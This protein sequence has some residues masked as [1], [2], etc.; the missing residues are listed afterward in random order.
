[1]KVKNLSIP[2]YCDGFYLVSLK[3]TI[4]NASSHRN[5]SLI[6]KVYQR[7]ETP[8]LR[9][10]VAEDEV[11]D[12]V[13]VSKMWYKDEVYLEANRNADYNRLTLGLVL[14]ATGEYCFEDEDKM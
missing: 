8:I 13:T 12:L 3:G 5:A 11:V 1:M 9:V 10:K 2:I 14:L 7:S 6:I 4:N